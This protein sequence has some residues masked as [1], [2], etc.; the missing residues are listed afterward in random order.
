[1]TKASCIPIEGEVA[2]GFEPVREAFTRS[3]TER[4]ELGAACA[5]FHEG[6]KVVDLWGG[7]SS[8]KRDKLWQEDTLVLVFSLSKGISALASALAV[9]RGN[10]AYEQRVAKYWPEFAEAGKKRVTVH[11]ALSEQAGLCTINIKLTAENQAAP[12]F[13]AAELAK[14]APEWIPGQWSGNHAYSIGYLHS[15]LIYRTDAYSRSL[16]DYFAEEIAEKLGID[17]YFGLPE[18]QFHRMARIQGFFMPRMLFH[19]RTL[20]RQM[21]LCLFLP[22][23]LTFRTLANPLIFNP[24]ALDK[25]EYWVCENGGAGGIGNAR[26]IA[27]LY[28]EFATG[29][30]KLGVTP[31]VL[32]DLRA[33]A[34]MPANGW[35]DMVLKTDLHY[36]LGLEKPSPGFPFGGGPSSYGSFAVGGS[37]AFADPDNKIG[38]AYT[39]NKLGFY[40]WNDPREKTV[41]DAFY[42]VLGIPGYPGLSRAKK[43]L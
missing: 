40:K 4:G 19:L 27:Q 31:E 9:A 15:E 35:R 43:L 14:Q 21:V 26:G 42:Q 5:I 11:E 7:Y 17:F 33:D 13:L 32:N 29:G 10:F 39:T 3:F 34:P 1:M 20:P 41:R 16:R 28:S 6:R 2:E 18:D 38:Y 22:W 25:P 24:D 30:D 12:R 36:S 23:T 37:M 8:G